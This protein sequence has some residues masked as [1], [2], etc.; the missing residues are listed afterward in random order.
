MMKEA[1]VLQPEPK[2]HTRQEALAFR[3]KAFLLQLKRGAENLLSSDVRR[4]PKGFELAAQPIIAE[5]KTALWTEKDRAEMPLMA[6][7]IHNLRLAIGK[8]N[9]IEI[10]ANQTFS[11]WRQ[12]GRATRRRSFVRGRELREGC[13]IPNVG[14]GLCQLS[15]ALYDAALQANFEIVERYAHTQIV[16]G[17]LAE[18]GRDATVFWNYVDLRFRSQN[19][20]RVEAELTATHLILR[21][22]AKEK[23]DKLIQLKREKNPLDSRLPTLNSPNSC[24]TCGVGECFRSE[25]PDDSID[26]GSAAFLLD[27]FSTEFD[28]YIQRAREKKDFLFVPLDGKR[29]KKANYA[30][31]TKGFAKIKQSLFVTLVRSYQSRKLAAQGAAR[32]KSLLAMAE[33]LAE[34]Y[35]KQLTFDATHIVV[36]QNLLPFLW[37]NGHLGGRTFDVLM[38]ALPMNELQKRLDFA[39]SLHPKSKTL[40]DFRAEKRLLE[41]EAEALRNARKIITPHTEIA[42]LFA[43]KAE[44]LDWQMPESR[45]IE[46]NRNEKFTVVFPASTVGRKGCYELREAL[47]DLDVKLV[48]LGATIE[49]ADFWRGFDW[50]KG[51]N[52]WLERAD[53]VVLPAFV[54]HKPRRLLQAAAHKIPVIAS[55]A[56]GVEN[57]AGITIV[58]NGNAEVLRAEIERILPANKTISKTDARVFV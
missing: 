15:N 31:E 48:T 35:A 45:E 14:G 47:R 36:S 39:A 21:F 49:D 18:K 5:S 10:P 12:I 38:T 46:R 33:K 6:G 24:M 17:S 23:S 57:V 25:K 29:F 3:A 30:W 44:L 1:S 41:A 52:D 54:E 55:R 4:L 16:A 11:F 9:G 32:Q 7:K 8:I 37:Q 42:S 13:V 40:G 56:C 22:K 28:E 43:E 20:F 26:F 53:L 19:A 51:G 34:S 27:E 2:I 50:E 58:E